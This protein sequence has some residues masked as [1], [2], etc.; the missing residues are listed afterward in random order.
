MRD[1]ALHGLGI[2][3]AGLEVGD[4][5]EQEHRTIYSVIFG[6]IGS[7]LNRVRFSATILDFQFLGNHRCYYFEEHF[8]H[9]V[10]ID[11]RPDVID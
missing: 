3:E 9:I 5:R 2:D 8:L 1:Y 11:G 6:A 4:V 10:N 7:H